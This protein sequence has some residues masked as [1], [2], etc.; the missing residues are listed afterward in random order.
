M[1]GKADG[2]GTFRWGLLVEARLSRQVTVGLGFLD[3][4]RTGVDPPTLALPAV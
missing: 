3:S 2:H 4:H 1:L